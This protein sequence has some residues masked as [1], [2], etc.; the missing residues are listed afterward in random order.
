MKKNMGIADRIVR[1]LIFATV[2]ILFFFTN[3][4][5]GVLG[6]VLLVAGGILALTSFV[7]FCPIYAL[8]GMRTC[9]VEASG[10]AKG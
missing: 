5:P 4:I 1:I 2:A 8:F 3:I 7:S 6:I 10:P 9:P